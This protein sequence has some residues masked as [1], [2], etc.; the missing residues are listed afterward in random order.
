MEAFDIKSKTIEEVEELLKF[1]NQ[2]AYRGKQLFNWLHKLGAQSYSE[3]HNLPKELRTFLE[4]NYPIYTCSVIHKSVSEKD[5]TAKYLLK[6]QDEQFVEAVLME[7]KHGFSLCISTQIGCKMGC[8]F[9]STGASGFSRNL[10]ASEMLSQIHSVEQEAGIRVSNVVLMGMGEPLDNYKNVLRFLRL[11]SNDE[12]LN[13]GMRNVTLSTCG[14]VPQI[15]DLAD[16]KLQLTLS[17]SLHAP[18]D[19]LR[20]KL[21]P[22]NR[23]YPIDRLLRACKYYVNNT[24]RRISFEYAMISGLNDTDEF[25]LLLAQ[26][27]KGILSHVNLIPINESDNCNYF[28]SDSGR[29][30]QFA[31]ILNS[32]GI[33][34][35][36]R[37]TLG[38]DIQGACG[39]L[40]RRFCAE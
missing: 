17:V 3:M 35:T 26:K 40:R 16:E 4:N 27:L 15:R 10:L 34:V 23:K 12:S 24:G 28:P 8:I 22:I 37:R 7:Y 30:N 19:N 13:I 6:M 18:E 14:L 31:E 9:C 29:I 39:Q 32:S 5:G 38:A 20:K 36:V 33:S 11:V 2:P 25:A 21:M 1:S